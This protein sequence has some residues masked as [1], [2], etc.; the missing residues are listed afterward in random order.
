MTGTY[1]LYSMQ[2]SGNCYKPRLTM[3]ELGI[4]FRIV[5]VV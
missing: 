5:E 2:A 4:P 3:H 1:T